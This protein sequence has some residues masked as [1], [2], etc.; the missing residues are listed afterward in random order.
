MRRI[1]VPVDGGPF[2]EH[3]L[4]TAVALAARHRSRLDLVLV[5]A[6]IHLA[7]SDGPIGQMAGLEAATR[8]EL[9]R[10]LTELTARTAAGRGLQVECVQLD[11]DPATE[12]SRFAYDRQPDLVVMCTHGRG[13]ISR[14]WLGSVADRLLRTIHGRILFVP[15]PGRG[16]APVPFHI[17]FV[18]LDGHLLAE[19][20]IAAARE[21]LA[22]HGVL[23]LGQCVEPV[24]AGP[25]PL[26]VPVL[27]RIATAAEPN[28]AA[29][30]Y[31][32]GQTKRLRAEG[33]EVRTVLG[34][35]PNPAHWI[36]ETAMSEEATLIA[37]STHGR[38]GFERIVLGSVTDKVIRGATVAVLACHPA[39][40]AL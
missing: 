38:G 28:D 37:I 12:L 6:P 32:A 8:M 26:E 35:D 1:M 36:L 34:E 9:G 20:A 31:L 29:A 25:F 39:A 3:A 22:P 40:P 14:F 27:P 19:R 7:A 2:A 33:L 10:Y 18:P 13:P 24:P 5:T 21:L 30:A 11:G 4:M 16:D 23:V 15:P 17:A